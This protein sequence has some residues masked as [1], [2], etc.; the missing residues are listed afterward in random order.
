VSVQPE[1]T[2]EGRVLFLERIAGHLLRLAKD[3]AMDLTEAV[4]DYRCDLIEDGV[5]AGGTLKRRP[6]KRHY[7]LTIELDER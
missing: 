4:E 3:E 1:R 6:G 2:F 5:D 7:R